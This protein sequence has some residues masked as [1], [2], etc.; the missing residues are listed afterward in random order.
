MFGYAVNETKSYMPLTID[1]SH[2]LSKRLTDVRKTG[3][4]PELRPME[5][6]G[7]S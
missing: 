5:K 3:V 6:S 7:L 4:I 1:L 2:Q